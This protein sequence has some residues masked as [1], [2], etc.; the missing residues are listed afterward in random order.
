[1]SEYTG[2][3]NQAVLGRLVEPDLPPRPAPPPTS[4]GVSHVLGH[5]RPIKA[6]VADEF[7][8]K[9]RGWT[10]HMRRQ[11]E[12]RGKDELIEVLG[13]KVE[14]AKIHHP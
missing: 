14:A 8:A 1:M 12:T 2:D 7:S 9:R 10:G 5:D 11:G 3:L 13:I 4:C 6:R